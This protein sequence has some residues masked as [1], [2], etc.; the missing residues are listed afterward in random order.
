MN[1]KRIAFYTGVAVVGATH[2]WLINGSLPEA[3]KTQH[4]YL[5]LA[6]AGLILWSAY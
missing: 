2:A 1:A 4:A 6:A 5:N 3:L